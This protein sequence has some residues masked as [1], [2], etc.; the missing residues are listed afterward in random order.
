MTALFFSAIR[1]T[2]R[3]VR[4][5][6]MDFLDELQHRV[7]PG[8]GAMGTELLAAGASLE[9]C[10]E[11]LNV[12]AQERVRVIHEGYLAAGARIIRTNSFGANAARLARHG[13]DHR[14]SELNWT[15][16]QLARDAARGHGVYVAG[17][18][19]PLHLD[20]EAARALGLDRSEIFTDQIGALLDGGCQ[21]I[22]LET[23]LD[24]E[25]LLVAL[26]AKHS[27]HHCPVVCSLVPDEDGALR[28]GTPLAEAFA[29]LRAAEA[30]L[31]A[32]N[33]IPSP[34]AGEALRDCADSG[35]LAAF[36]SAGLPE[37]L[38]GKAVYHTMPAEFAA[39]GLKLAEQG[40][41]LIGGCCGI[42]PRHIAA[43]TAA[44]EAAA[45]R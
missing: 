10:L 35:P 32:V 4:P 2:A 28:D 6:S 25:E 15:A 26:E 43:F 22:F 21:L 11:E 17:S 45:P 38:D 13:L 34:A 29:A 44:L 27:L 20:E 42:G 33:C 31:V 19:G 1:E 8:D 30:D 41:R 7:L 12:S 36:P 16:A 40:V 18:V 23:F 39:G 9:T 5:L 14:V 37:I 3:I 24:L